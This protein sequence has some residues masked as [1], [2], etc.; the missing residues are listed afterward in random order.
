LKTFH[1]PKSIMKLNLLL[2][3]ATALVN[4]ATA[5]DTVQLGDAGNYVILAKT[6]ISTV[7]TSAIT[8]SIAV[9]PITGAAITGFD[10]V[11]DSLGAF[12]TATQFTGKAFAADFAAPS[13]V[14]LTAAVG[15]ME[16]AY[17]DATGRTNTDAA[18]VNLGDGAIGGKTLTPGVYTFDRDISIGTATQ[19]TFDAEGDADA[20]FIIRTSK[21]LLQA[22]N[23]NVILAGEAQ[24]RNIFWQVAGLVDVGAGA[25][26]EG[27]LLV[28]TSVTFKTGSSLLGRVLAQ[29]ACNLQMATIT[30]A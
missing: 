20:V 15:D 21:S 30:E 16:I 4:A 18:N 9:S 11:M 5:I 22:A 28:K 26:L 1:Q 12:A 24:A 8:G 23:T 7:P 19:V 6:G 2:L 10:L 25:H 3:S 27:V 14:D 17:T 29:T 13:P